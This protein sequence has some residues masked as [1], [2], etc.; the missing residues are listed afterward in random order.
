MIADATQTFGVIL[1]VAAAV[2]YLGLIA[3]RAAKGK[4][5]GGCSGCRPMSRPADESSPPEQLV[6]TE[7]LADRARQLADDQKSS[8]SPT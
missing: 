7:D 6:P 4:G 8:D 2:G 5:G 1:L 3:R